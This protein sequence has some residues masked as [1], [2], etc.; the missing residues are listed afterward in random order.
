MRNRTIASIAVSALT[1][2]VVLAAPGAAQAA[3]TQA[4]RSTGVVGTWIGTQR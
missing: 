2:A 1:T 3:E 4:S